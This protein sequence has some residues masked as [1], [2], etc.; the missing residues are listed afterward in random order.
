MAVL[1]EKRTTLPERECYKFTI[2]P[3][4]MRA[5]VRFYALSFGGEEMT[6]D[7]LI[8]DLEIKGI[9]RGILTDAIRECFVKRRDYCKDILVAQD[10]DPVHGTDACIE[11]YFNTDR[12]AETAGCQKGGFKI[13]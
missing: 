2:T 11:Y 5:Y 1:L 7:E 6:A 4:N 9:R 10:T 12:K 13:W 8:K 3:D